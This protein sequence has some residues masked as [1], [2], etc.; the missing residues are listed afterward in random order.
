M[1]I[2]LSILFI[3]GL[4]I[5]Q[6]G[7]IPIGSGVTVYVQDI[8]L[9]LLLGYVLLFRVRKK[10]SSKIWIPILSFIGVCIMSIAVNAYRFTM[11][12]LLISALYG[13]RWMGYASLFILVFKLPQRP[14][15]WL[16]ALYGFGLVVASLG[17]IQYMWYPYL[18][19]LSYLGWDPHLYRVFS[20]M[21]DPNFA[22]ILFVCTFLLGI[23]LWTQTKRTWLIVVGEIV[24]FTALLLTYSRSGYLALLS[25][26]VVVAMVSKY[27]RVMGILCVVFIGV[28][29]ILPHKDGEGV[30]LLRTVSTVARI[31]NW[32]RGGELIRDAPVFGHGFN[33]LR[34]VQ[35]AKGWVDDSVMVSHAGAGL[36][37]SIEFVWATTGVLG[38]GVY[39][40]IWYEIFKMLQRVMKKKKY[41]ILGIIGIA[42]CVAVLVDSQFS[43]S[44]FYPQVMAW[45]W[46]L[47]A[48]IERMV[49]FDTKS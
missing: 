19:N 30:K 9:G 35:R 41:T 42:T 23:Y 5:G 44:L 1:S 32:Q 17:L 10:I 29:F 26:G 25:S 15:W 34:Y 46:I 49:S 27:K 48:S 36:D 7:G 45:M 28:L 18:R 13:V 3:C 8:F 16:W 39:I 20:T 43:N 24:V 6:V 14:I 11:S 38:L 12:E 4:V 31:G 21:F 40:W 37:S 33:T 2:V 22:A 47:T